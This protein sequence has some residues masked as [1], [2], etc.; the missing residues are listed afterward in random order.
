MVEAIVIAATI[1]FQTL[2]GATSTSL[3]NTG[4]SIGPN[5]PGAIVVVDTLE[6][7]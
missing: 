1:T 5:Q 6:M 4:T 3:P 7:N 2:F